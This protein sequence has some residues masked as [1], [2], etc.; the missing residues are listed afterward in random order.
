LRKKILFICLCLLVILFF[1]KNAHSAAITNDE[2]IG[3]HGDKGLTK[4]VP[5]GKTIS[6]F[7]DNKLFKK[8]V[9][10]SLQ[11]IN[12]HEIKELPHPEKLKAADCQSCHDNAYKQY[13]SSVHA[14]GEKKNASCKDCHGYH[15]V[16]KAESLVS[17]V[18]SSCHGAAYRE[19]TTGIH[20]RVSE[21]I[22]EVATCV[23]CHGKSHAIHKKNNPFSSV[24][25]LNLPRTCSR[26][27][28]NPDM[29][30]KYK[31]PAENVYNLYMDSIHGLAIAKSTIG[32]SANCSNCHGSHA[33]KPH[34]DPTSQIYPSHV[35]ATCGKCHSGI[36]TVF[37]K[38]THGQELKRGNKDAPSCV[39]CHPAH[40][41]QPVKATAWILDVI[42]ECGSCHNALLETYRHTYH[43]KI[44]NLGFTRVAKC[45][46]CHGAHEVLPKSDPH[47][48]ISENNLLGT[49]RQCHPDANKNFTE[50]VVHIDYK[51]KNGHPIF[52]YV[53]RFMIILLIA[54]FGFFGIHA[55]LWLPRSWIERIQQRKR[56]EENEREK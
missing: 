8:S 25:V 56:K 28:A 53:W 40:Q 15:N 36:E 29:V 16:H 3:C 20:A 42:K 38:S 24:Y 43:G 34:T 23:D 11:C 33:I 52:F 46:D 54:V 19:Y 9:H 18:C 49:C 35:P 26:C 55:L 51:N 47:S 5:G 7:L 10:L 45:A 31:I 17:S 27:H 50:F 30:K 48:K 1:L 13:M 39:S 12:C 14:K 32:V 22:R 6:L 41:I 4:T 21:G 44:T 2:C 37:K